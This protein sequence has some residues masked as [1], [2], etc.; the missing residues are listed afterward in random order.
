MTT[1]PVSHEQYA[2]TLFAE[3]DGLP[4]FTG[5]TYEDHVEGWHAIDASE[6]RHLWAK[7]AIAA[8][9]ERQVNQWH[10]AEATDL[11]RFAHD[12]RCSGEWVRVLAKT[13]RTFAAQPELGCTLPLSF[14]H[15]AVAAMLA[16]T[17]E[18]AHQALVEAHD[19]EWSTRELQR[20]L[21]PSGTGAAIWV[22]VEAK[23]AADAKRLCDQM[24]REGRTAKVVQR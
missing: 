2:L 5:T 19:K 21:R 8:S 9:L 23:D 3:R 6:Q 15:Y 10:G 22:L 1:P 13:Y 4:Q 7:A 14:K 18:I 17:P 24:E 11:Q 12:V 20:T 16:K